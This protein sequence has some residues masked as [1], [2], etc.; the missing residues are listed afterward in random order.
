MDDERRV[1]GCPLTQ[2]T[3]NQVTAY[4]KECHVTVELRSVRAGNHDLTI[5]AVPEVRGRIVTT[6][7]GRLLRRVGGASEP[8]RG[9][10]VARFVTDRGQVSA[11]EEPLGRA[12]DP[13]DFDSAT[14]ARKRTRAASPNWLGVTTQDV[15]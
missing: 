14:V 15:A 10:A 9:D 1:V 6:P 5:V 7:D 3:Q 12:F 11:E 8:L 13:A 4:A 2:R